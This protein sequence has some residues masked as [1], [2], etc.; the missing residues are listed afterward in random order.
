MKH[1]IFFLLII[2]C[3]IFACSKSKTEPEVIIHNIPLD[4]DRTTVA[5]KPIQMWID[6]H[7]NFSRF[8]D[9]ANITTYIE[10][11][12]ATG[13]NELYVDVKPGI[14]YALYNSD[15]LP[16]LTKWDNE[17]VNR[18][19][20]YLGF[21]IEEA[22]RLNMKVIA[23]LSVMGYGYTKTREGLIYNDSKWNGKTQMEMTNS[24]TPTVLTDMRDQTGVDAAMLNPCLPEVQS[25]VL[26]IIAEI[27]T[28]Y[29]K[30]KGICLDYCRWYGGNYGFGD[31]TISAFQTY[32]GKT[33]NSNNDIITNSGGIGPLY[34]DWIE[35]RTQTI[36]NLVTN[37]RS[38]IK[39]IN[40]K[41]ELHLWASA[42]WSS[43]YS[44]GQNWASKKYVPASS[45]RY[46]DNYSK[47][48]FADQ[49]DVFSLG[50]Y[51]EAVW[52][53][54]NPGSVWSVENFVTTYNN[55]TKGDCKVN[56]SFASYAYGSNSTAISDV[57]YLCLKNTDGLMAFEL[58]H[59]I[60]NNQWSAIKAGIDR[61]Y[62]K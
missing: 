61:V 36:T 47:T 24:Q 12:K 23:S 55:F 45:T 42:D 7:A 13:F 11:M 46:T 19:W 21:W 8:A 2:T 5:D 34:K 26:S 39:S 3:S 60:N 31:A 53:S 58:S 32:S 62:K 20:D 25:F 27:A 29:P 49:L 52:A 17:T 10:K 30:L 33:V 41:M 9:K 43:R 48:G 6:A 14:G 57:V 35:F 44:V 50:A 59:V 40:P 1:C 18:N 54:E 16:K 37:I 22:E 28:K 51:T 56:G 15:I 4:I 38:K